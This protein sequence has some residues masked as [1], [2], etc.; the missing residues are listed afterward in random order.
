MARDGSGT[1]TLPLPS[2]V[3]GTAIEASWAN[4]T[5][6]DVAASLSDSL[7][8]SGSGAMSVQIKAVDGTK[9]VPGFGFNSESTSGLYRSGAG[10]I[11]VTVLNTDIARFHSSSG[12]QVYNNA[13]WRDVFIGTDGSAEGQLTKWDNS[14]GIWI[15]ATTLV[16]DANGSLWIG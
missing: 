1:Y 9:T 13:A 2:V 12:F 10:D 16:Q 3:T 6:S 7:S 15:P 4:T 5:L 8:R 14:N 11:R